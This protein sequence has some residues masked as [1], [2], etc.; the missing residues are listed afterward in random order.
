L[1]FACLELRRATS[2]D[3]RRKR[4]CLSAS[5][6]MQRRWRPGSTE[7]K[8]P[9]ATCRQ[10]RLASAAQLDRQTRQAQPPSLPPRADGRAE[11]RPT[12]RSPACAPMTRA[13]R[14]LGAALALVMGEGG[15]GEEGGVGWARKP[16]NPWLLIAAAAPDCA[17][18]GPRLRRA[19]LL[20]ASLTLY[21]LQT[22]AGCTVTDFPRAF[23]TCDS[24]TKRVNPTRQKR[25]AAMCVRSCPAGVGDTWATDA[26]RKEEAAH[27][28]ASPR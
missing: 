25:A 13:R 23:D 26:D 28:P 8:L 4:L 24:D 15:A 17:S 1:T 2:L 3:L 6:A 5:T 19:P 11:H 14:Q 10:A 20:E 21:S 7:N 12:T 18:A 22:R 16:T 27:R 9:G